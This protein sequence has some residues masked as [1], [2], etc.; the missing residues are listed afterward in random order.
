MINDCSSKCHPESSRAFG[1][2]AKDENKQLFSRRAC[3]PR[4][5]GRVV[6][7]LQCNGSRWTRR[8]SPP[9]KHFQS[10]Y[11]EGSGSFSGN[12]IHRCAQDDSS[13]A[14]DALFPTP[15]FTNFLTRTIPDRDG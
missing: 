8:A 11:S 14:S 15:K 12:Q 6:G 3:S 5:K 4:L 13:R 2:P 9:A 1:T 7:I 10:R